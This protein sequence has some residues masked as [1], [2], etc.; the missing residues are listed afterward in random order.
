LDNYD[1]SECTSSRSH[2]KYYETPNIY[3]KKA[4]DLIKSKSTN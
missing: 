3:T 2:I 1:S 4:I